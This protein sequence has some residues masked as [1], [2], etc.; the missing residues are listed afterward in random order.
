MGISTRNLLLPLLCL[1]IFGHSGQSF[2]HLLRKAKCLIPKD[3]DHLTRALFLQQCISDKYGQ[4]NETRCYDGL[5][6][7]HMEKPW[8]TLSRPFPTPFPPEDIDTG[9]TLYT[10]KAP[11][12][13]KL[14]LWPKITL[15]GSDFK[16]KRPATVFMTHGFSSNGN[17][18]WLL[19]MK[20]AYLK[21]A[22][23]N[24]FI[25]DWGEGAS[26]LNYLQVASNIRI[27]G[28]ELT[29][30]GKYLIKKG[31]NPDKIHLIGHSL[32][33]HTMGYLA[34]GLSS[35]KLVRRITALDPAQPGFEGT[36][37]Q[38]RLA[39]G[40]AQYIDVIHT[41]AKAFIPLIGFGMMQPV[42]DVDFYMNGGSSQPGCIQIKLPNITGILDL[43]KIPVEVIS[44]WV[45]C[46]HGR[47]Y[48]YF[49]WALKLENCSFWG[50]KMS[51][52]ENVLKITTAG[53]LAVLDPLVKSLN[54]C[55]EENCSVLG[56]KTFRLKAR[57]V[58]AVTTKPFEP[59]CDLPKKLSLKLNKL[60]PSL[61]NVVAGT[62][63]QLLALPI[64]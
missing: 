33:A 9:I 30:F 26:L 58:F 37:E 51:T 49:T 41:D 57:G 43:A 18:D 13:Y 53:M 55:T 5:G 3:I 61:L 29:R 56:L 46:S 24:V 6:C 32:G 36:D 38:V 7:F 2:V 4:G 22:D 63:G 1:V 47:A 12:G 17:A 35:S 54:Y 59:F 45:S 23:V 42:G 8:I 10:R 20:D 31:L 27:V 50:R 34:K 19:D 48:E 28:S 62:L 60:V 52:V 44:N 16:A 14:T 25:V 11:K 40:D 64:F 21:N 15:K 39:K